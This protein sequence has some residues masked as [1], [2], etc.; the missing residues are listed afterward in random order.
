MISALMFADDFVGLAGSPAEL[1]AGVGA[2]RDWCG[3]WRMQANVG[4]GKT[5]VMLFAP[6]AA[7]APLLD[8]DL[9]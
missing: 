6:A 9:V 7:A 4:P 5:A 2:A 8:R 1:Q 3:K